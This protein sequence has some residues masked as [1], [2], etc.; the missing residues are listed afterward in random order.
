VKTITGV[1]AMT[2]GAV[3]ETGVA[4]QAETNAASDLCVVEIGQY[5]RKQIKR[6][7]K[8]EGKLLADVQNVVQGMKDDGVLVSGSHTVVVVVREEFSMRSM[9]D[10]D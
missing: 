8:G 5:S 6:L 2:D 10:Q 1:N 4:P 3:A 9:L 7:R